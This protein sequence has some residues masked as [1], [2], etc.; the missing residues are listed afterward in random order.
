MARAG[1]SAFEST[2]SAESVFAGRRMVRP[3][4]GP[5]TTTDVQTTIKNAA[6]APPH[7][8]DDEPGYR[9]VSWLGCDLE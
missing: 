8:K 6:R 3:A 7:A 1:N 9:R 2:T 4:S 5:R